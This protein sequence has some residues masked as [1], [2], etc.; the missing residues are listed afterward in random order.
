MLNVYTQ[1]L[2][3]Q[4]AMAFVTKDFQKYGMKA[5]QTTIKSLVRMCVRAKKFNLAAVVLDT[6]SDLNRG[7]VSVSSRNILPDGDTLGFLIEGLAKVGD[8]KGALYWVEILHDDLKYPIKEWY[9]TRLRKGL[10]RLGIRHPLIQRGENE[11]FD[12]VLKTRKVK[13]GKNK[14]RL[15]QQ[16]KGFS[17]N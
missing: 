1:P 17:Y 9:V 13:P 4:T 5:D 11:W 6:L 2:W 3:L 14:S 12:D 7:V 15:L 10:Q 16:V 8:Y